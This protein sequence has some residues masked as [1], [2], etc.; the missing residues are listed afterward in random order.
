MGQIPSTRPVSRTVVTLE[1]ERIPAAQAQARRLHERAHMLPRS[2]VAA[3]ASFAVVGCI[4]WQDLP[5]PS[6]H[7]NAVYHG[8]RARGYEGT[9]RVG[10]WTESFS[11]GS[12][13]GTVVA[14]R[15]VVTARHCTE[16]A[17]PVDI[18]VET[19]REGEL[20]QFG[21]AEV[22]TTEGAL[23]D[24][25]D[26]A[27]LLLADRLD[28]D[29][30]PYARSWAPVAGAPLTLVG[31]GLTHDGFVGIKNVGETAVLEVYERYVRAHGEQN[32]C[33]G[34]SGG[35]ALDE[36]GTLVGVITHH[37]RGPD[38]LDTCEGAD[39]GLNRVDVW[40]AMVD[41]AVADTTI[42][43][44]SEICGDAIDD[45][46]DGTLDDGCIWIGA[47]C[48]TS[49][50]CDT[51]DC[52]ALGGES[53]CTKACTP[54]TFVEGCPEPTQCRLLDDGSGACLRDSLPD[55]TA[56]PHAPGPDDGDEPPPAADEPA[57]TATYGCEMTGLRPQHHLL[58]V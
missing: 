34:D 29:P 58:A 13:S 39:S 3:I 12:C 33:F 31:Y 26:V 25:N 9:V 46:C 27:V 21:V 4:G 53:V 47:P 16:G 30:V 50:Q 52:R 36:T 56:P 43:E 23:I 42:C 17:L 5:A 35:T 18:V 41:Q 15:V 8:E 14:P 44:T 38:P 10:R 11:Y 51:G 6:S 49:L 19:G 37:F 28:V 22:R 7:Q 57:P 32:S 55:E 54:G 24:D 40:S 1:P 48:V 20:G 45:D 2:A